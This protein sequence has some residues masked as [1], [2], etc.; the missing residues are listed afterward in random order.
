MYI[1]GLCHTFCRRSGGDSIRRA[2]GGLRRFANAG[3]FRTRTRA[4]ARVLQ[5][6]QGR[7]RSFP[8]AVYFGG[9]AGRVFCG[10]HVFHNS[11]NSGM[12][13]TNTGPVLALEVNR[14]SFLATA[15]AVTCACAMGCPFAEA[16]DAKDADIAS[17][18]IGTMADFPKDGP[19][20]KFAKKP[21][22]LIIVR[23]GGK[24]YAMTSVC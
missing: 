15:A 3:C 14:R 11:E 18:D 1:R 9:T 20:D 19:Y 5:E 6:L 17:V 22:S 13:E 16:A 8:R 10:F 21:N 24:L 4:T 7:P 12:S 2:R 23:E